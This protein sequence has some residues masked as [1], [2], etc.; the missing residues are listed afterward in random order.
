VTNQTFIP[1]VLIVI[2]AFFVPLLAGRIPRFRIPSSVAEIVVGII[3]GKS[4]F[5]LIHEV[6]PIDFL[7]DFG[8]IFLMF[9]SGFDVDTSILKTGK[10]RLGGAF[11]PLAVVAG[12][13][14]LALVSSYSVTYLGWF[15]DNI[16]F[17]L[18]LSTTSVGIVLPVIKET[19]DTQTLYGQSLIITALLADVISIVLLTVYVVCKSGDPGTQFFWM[20]GL[21][22]GFFLL[23]VVLRLVQRIASFTKVFD[24]LSHTSAQIK[25][26]GGLALLIIFVVLF[27]MIGVEAI[28]GAFIA[29]LLLSFL[30]KTDKK[31]T[32]LKFDAIGFG[33]FIPIFFV[34]VGAKLDLP[35]LFSTTRAIL[36]LPLLLLL[37]YAVKILPSLLFKMAGF[38]Y[39]RCIAAGILLSSRLALIVA[40]SEIA[41][42][43]GLI[44][45][46]VNSAIVLTAIFTSIVSP[47][48]YG[49]V[50]EKSP[51]KKPKVIIAGAGRVGREVFERIRRH[52]PDVMLIDCDP[53][54]LQKLPPESCFINADCND[55][56]ALEKSGINPN[57]VFVALT[58]SD[59]Q[60]LRACLGVKQR[61]GLTRIIARDNNPKNTKRFSDAGV[62]PLNL[63]RSI[64]VAVENL[65]LRPSLVQLFDKEIDT[66]GLFVFEVLVKNP[67]YFNV[68]IK[69]ARN[70][71]NALVLVVKKGDE[72]RIPHGDT[73]LRE[74]DSVVACGFA[75]DEY[76]MRDSLG[77]G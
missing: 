17:A 19:S 38:S 28:L 69:N 30:I 54:Q 59:D 57:D 33:F 27:E 6:A 68:K 29:G 12:T 21:V 53:E 67:A 56:D 37:A 18:I 42:S 4:G 49:R 16:L 77:T 14:L 55:L 24:D 60:N 13:M 8:F 11:A 50:R 45:D 75:E 51:Q 44:D 1:L 15:E 52:T 71:G 41:R 26:R 63:T 36:L 43:L 2:V 5:G 40:A 70:L 25:I 48:V 46:T 9:L 7:A 72:I 74:D 76:R 20:A 64:A 62:I 39:R 66:E 22:L 34:M 58:G 32:S 10:K 73:V 23:F 35:L 31:I 61:F 3:L 65:A 47:I